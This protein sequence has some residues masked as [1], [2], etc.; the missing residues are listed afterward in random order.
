MP[1]GI[2]GSISNITWGLK[3]FILE[4]R[5]EKME[6]KGMEEKGGEDKEGRKREKQRNRG[7]GKIREE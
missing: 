1:V 2:S 3:C 6:G 5:G 7:K 4:R